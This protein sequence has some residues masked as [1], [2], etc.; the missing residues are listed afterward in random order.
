MCLE[1]GKLKGLI[2]VNCQHNVCETCALF[3]EHKGHD[4]RQQQSIMLDIRVRMEK[5]MDTFQQLD[6]DCLLLQEQEEL[7]QRHSLMENRRLELV[8]QAEQCIEEVKANLDSYLLDVKQRITA[9]FKPFTEQFEQEQGALKKL[10]EEGNAINQHIRKIV[11]DI[12]EQIAKS[13]SYIAY[14][15]LDDDP[16]NDSS[17]ECLC[18]QAD[19]FH[20]QAVLRAQATELDRDLEAKYSRISVGLNGKFKQSFQDLISVGDL[21]DSSKQEQGPK[22]LKVLRVVQMKR[23]AAQ[24][25]TEKKQKGSL[26]EEDSQLLESLGLNAKTVDEVLQLKIDGLKDQLEGLRASDLV[27][28]RDSVEAN[29]DRLNKDDTLVADEQKM[30]PI[31]LGQSK[32]QNI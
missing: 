4:V 13:P 2:C 22:H 12:T 11:D 5:L 27:E 10:E 1:H 6:Q 25:K 19:I 18:A 17:V 24:P 32:K 20:E 8:T 31:Q 7:K 3:G 23:H 29:A 30:P 16:L 9:S 28:K 21:A 15:L 26:L 14:N